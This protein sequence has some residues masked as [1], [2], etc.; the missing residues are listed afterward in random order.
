MKDSN[1][2]VYV[3]QVFASPANI[4]K[5]CSPSSFSCCLPPWS[6][7]AQENG[8]FARAGQHVFKQPRS[9]LVEPPDFLSGSVC[10]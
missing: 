4:C 7:E 5:N 8:E 10:V 2:R 9:Y 6:R 1:I 3:L